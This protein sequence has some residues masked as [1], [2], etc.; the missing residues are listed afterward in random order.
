MKRLTN[1]RRTSRTA[2]EPD[3]EAV[4]G[5][6]GGHRGGL[7]VCGHHVEECGSGGG[8]DGDVSG[9]KGEG[10]SRH[11]NAG[12]RRDEVRG[13]GADGRRRRR[14]DNID[15]EGRCDETGQS[16]DNQRLNQHLRHTQHKR[17]DCLKSVFE[18][19]L[20][21]EEVLDV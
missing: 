16:E 10:K 7:V 9:I 17:Q 8:V 20:S 5:R 21:D 11:V 12:K 3:Q 6:R 1:Q 4:G 14:R 18:S 2:L 19:G 15:R 13:V